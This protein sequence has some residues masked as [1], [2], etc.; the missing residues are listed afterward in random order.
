MEGIKYYIGKKVYI[1]LKN[2]RQYS[3]EVIE[4]DDNS[5]P[6]I[7]I[8]ILDKFG[9]KVMFERSEIEVLEEEGD[10]M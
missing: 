5:N 6:L 3:G 1:I 2:G 4:I 10:E 7:F 8:T 9:N